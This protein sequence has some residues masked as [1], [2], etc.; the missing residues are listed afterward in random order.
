MKLQKKFILQCDNPD[1]KNMKKLIICFI[2]LF[3]ASCNNNQE[4]SGDNLTP[5]EESILTSLSERLN[6]HDTSLTGIEMNTIKQSFQNSPLAHAQLLY[7]YT[8]Y[9]LNIHPDS[10]TKYYSE[11][12]VAAHKTE[13]DS[14]K[15]NLYLLSDYMMDNDSAILNRL[16]MADSIAVKIKNEPKHA[17]A[18]TKLAQFYYD[19]YP[20]KSI[21]YNNA[22]ADLFSKLGDTRWAGFSTQNIAFAYY[23]KKDNPSKAEE[24]MKKALVYWE[25]M[26]DTL[27]EANNI[28]Y[29]GMLQGKLHKFDEAKGSIW[30]AINKFESRNY[31]FGTAVSYFDL[32]SVY[33]DENKKDSAIYYLKKAKE[34]WETVSDTF[35][36]FGINNFCFRLYLADKKLREAYNSYT[37]NNTMIKC[38]A[39]Y[40]LDKLNFYNYSQNYFSKKGEKKREENYRILYTALK[41]SLTKSGIQIK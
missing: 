39:V 27:G 29:L 8:K 4:K 5:A 18:L 19:K 9:F 23:E 7:L 24:Y 10:A 34:F 28:K 12:E 25:Q 30:K 36:L 38:E 21:E 13:N 22:A 17:S 15:V 14:V 26:N 16:L 6:K 20:D 11:F 32:A 41:D 33:E 2:F 31:K 3:S 40:W 1:R 35:R 37:A